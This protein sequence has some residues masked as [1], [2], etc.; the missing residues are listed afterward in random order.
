MMALH[1]T[2]RGIATLEDMVGD[3]GSDVECNNLYCESEHRRD[4]RA[5]L[6][7]DPAHFGVGVLPYKPHIPVEDWKDVTVIPVRSTV[8]NITRSGRGNNL[9]EMSCDRPSN[10][11]VYK[12]ERVMDSSM[13]E[14][15][16]L[17]VWKLVFSRDISESELWAKKM[18]NSSKTMAKFGSSKK[19]GRDSGGIANTRDVMLALIEYGGKSGAPVDMNNLPDNV[20]CS[21]IERD[22]ELGG[23][24]PF[25]PEYALNGRRSEA[26]NCGIVDSKGDPLDVHPVYKDIDNYFDGKG[27]FSIPRDPDNFSTFFVDPEVIKDELRLIHS[28]LEWSR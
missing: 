3:P 18:R 14:L 11:V 16:A 12:M 15:F 24:H 4:A 5:M 21:D 26:L 17:R 8:I 10:R 6:D 28:M 9:F 20:L 25:G 27:R 7:F 1:S 19:R 22:E 13:T 2:T 23:L